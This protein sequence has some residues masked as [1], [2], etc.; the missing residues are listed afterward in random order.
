ML[1]NRVIQMSYLKWHHIRES[2]IFIPYSNLIAGIQKI[3]RMKNN[4]FEF[5]VISLHCHSLNRKEK[6]NIGYRFF[7]AKD[8]NHRRSWHVREDR[9][10][11]CHTVRDQAVPWGSFLCFLVPRGWSRSGLPIKQNRHP[12]EENRSR[13][14]QQ[15]RDP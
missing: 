7:S 3:W 10:H 6:I 1:S 14:G 9:K 4:Y 11:S 8:R 15:S 5:F 13:H 2:L 12:N